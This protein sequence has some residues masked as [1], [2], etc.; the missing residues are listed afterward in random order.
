MQLWKTLLHHLLLST[1]FVIPARK[2][3]S[4]VIISAIIQIGAAR[5]LYQPGLSLNCLPINSPRETSNAADPIAEPQ[6]L[7]EG[8]THHPG[9]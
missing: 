5:V 9:Q 2:K 6:T 8:D 4:P 7:H 1:L 3:R